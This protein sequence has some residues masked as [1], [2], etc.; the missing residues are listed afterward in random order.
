[1]DEYT[2]LT[3]ERRFSPHLSNNSIKNVSQEHR[4]HNQYM[5]EEESLTSSRDDNHEDK[6]EPQDCRRQKQEHRGEKMDNQEDQPD[7][8]NLHIKTFF[9]SLE[10]ERRTEAEVSFTGNRSKCAKA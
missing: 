9:H 6:E 10:R 3:F 4:K 2:L 1:M 5:V 7:S 8:R